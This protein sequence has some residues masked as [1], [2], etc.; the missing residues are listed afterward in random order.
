MKINM[1]E[2]FVDDEMR[3]AVLRVLESKRYVKG[4]EAKKFEEEFSFFCNTKH[5]IATNSGTSAL[6]VALL[7]VGLKPSDEVIIPSHT[8]VATASPLL[9][10]GAQ[11]VFAEINEET[12]TMDPEDVEKKITDKTKAIIPVHLYGHPCNMNPLLDLANENNLAVI[13]DACQAHGAEYEG[14][15][16]G[17][18][19]DMACFSFFPSKNMTVAG[20]GGMITTSNEEYAEVAEALVN[21]GRLA[22]KKYEHDYAGFNYRMSEILAA[23][24]R[25]QLKHLPEW[26][27]KR[28]K[29]AAWYNEM[30]DNEEIILPIEKNLAKHVYH[31]YV[32]R[33][34][35][36]EALRN[37]LGDH[38]VGTGVHYP[39]PVHLQPSIKKSNPLSLKTTEKIVGEVLSLPIHPQLKKEDVKWV[40]ELI[41]GWKK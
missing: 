34:E 25:V 5:G 35:Q 22:G 32:V 38:N 41:N 11:P 12:Y 27:E 14:K 30:L 13:E 33:T 7:T 36:R 3:G 2:M 10:I 31:L 17:S 26:I 24:G 8:F 16:I 18:M 9:H 23:I 1:A 29:V 19:G 15:K 37:Y 6:H 40:C 39:L 20:E 28:R 21:Q 4:R